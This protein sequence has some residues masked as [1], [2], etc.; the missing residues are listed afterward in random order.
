MRKMMIA[1]A[2][3]LSAA[4]L[5]IPATAQT[6]NIPAGLVNVN[7]SDITLTDILSQNEIDV[8]RNANILNGTQV[9]V[10]VSVAAAV[11]NIP[12]NVLASQRNTTFAD[13]C[14]AST[15]GDTTQLQRVL[16][17]Q[18]RQANK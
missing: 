9:A 16:Q 13:G 10:P 5:T 4:S 12:V 17:R 2:L 8:L 11:C 7:V 3:G 14:K 6:V 1:A 15:E 18:A